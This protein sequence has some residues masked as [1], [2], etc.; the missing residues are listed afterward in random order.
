MIYSTGVFYEKCPIMKSGSKLTILILFFLLTNIQGY[1]QII[2]P[3]SAAKASVLDSLKRT[4]AIFGEYLKKPDISLSNEQALK[5]LSGRLDARYWKDPADPLRKAM[6]Q[7]VSNA[8]NPP[9]DSTASFLKRYP[10]DSL[11]IPWD[12]FYIWE[13]LRVKVPVRSIQEPADSAIKPY[14]TINEA[15][16]DSLVLG[17]LIQN[18][19]LV[20][21]LA[22]YI[23]TTIYVVIDTLDLVQPDK[24]GFP[25]YYEHP[26]QGDSTSVAVRKLMDFLEAR[27]STVIYFTGTGL[28]KTPVWLNSKADVMKRYWLRND[29]NDSVTIWIGAPSRNTIGLYLEQGVSFRRPVIQGNYSGAKIEVKEVDKSKLLEAQKITVKQQIWKYRTEASFAL[30]QTSLTNW[31]KGGESNIS[32]LLDV[33]EY[34]DYTDKIHKITSNNFA[35]LKYG[36]IWSEEKGV[37]KN[38]DLLETNSKVNH[39]AFGK[40]DFSGIMLFKTQIAKGYN[41]PNDVVAVSKFMNPATLTIGFGL[42]Y[43]PN[44]TTSIN[45]SPFSYKGTFVT[46]TST[47]DPTNGIDQTKY[48]IPANRRSMHEPGVSFL[49]TN[50]FKPVKTVSVVNRVQL[51]TNYIDHPQNIDIDWEMILTANLNWFTDVRFNTHL[52]YD[53]NTKT[54]VFDKQGNKVLVDGK[55]KKTA[56][57]QFKEMLGFSLVFRF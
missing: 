36:L 13:P 22:G 31:V 11:E 51:F 10:L 4:G 9:F 28:G 33:T 46:D 48:G 32:T 12:K 45:F 57:A 8:A 21:K 6:M 14:S 42:D 27:D 50:E 25:Y 38:L 47:I 54:P 3:D 39:K 37:R 30:N 56:R 5:F 53:D 29:L 18:D 24:P 40:F 26:F 55:Q 43:K 2:L 7:L 49:I 35:R 19:T 1:S 34:A 52:I 16:H 15:V 23:D 41:Y 17:N 20:R 44:K